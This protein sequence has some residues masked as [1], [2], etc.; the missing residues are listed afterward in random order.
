LDIITFGTQ[1]EIESIVC[2]D[3]FS[4]S[5]LSLHNNGCLHVYFPSADFYPVRDENRFL[6]DGFLLYSTDVLCVAGI[7]RIEDSRFSIFTLEEF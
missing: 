4:L 5:L 3:C 7:E 2:V 1:E 6:A